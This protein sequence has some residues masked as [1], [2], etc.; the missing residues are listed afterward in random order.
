MPATGSSG[1]ATALSAEDVILAL[2]HGLVFT[3]A[4]CPHSPVAV[5]T[6]HDD[7]S[8]STALRIRLECYVKADLIRIIPIGAIIY[9]YILMEKAFLQG[10]GNSVFCR[11]VRI[12]KQADNSYRDEQDKR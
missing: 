8:D 11:E 12:Y 10:A 6:Y 5:T 2:F 1:G 3:G 4:R 9:G 7:L